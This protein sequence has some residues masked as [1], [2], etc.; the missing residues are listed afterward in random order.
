MT[1]LT[2]KQL[3]HYT[4]KGYISLINVLSS[5]EAKEIKE[6]SKIFYSGTKGKGKY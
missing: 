5:S 3:D 6:L 1:G 2:A 4:K